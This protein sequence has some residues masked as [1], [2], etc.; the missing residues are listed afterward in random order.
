MP[1]CFRNKR[2][3]FLPTFVCRFSGFDRIYICGRFV[4]FSAEGIRPS[5][6]CTNDIGEI[7]FY[8]IWVGSDENNFSDK[9][10]YTKCGLRMD[11]LTIRLV[12]V[13]ISLK[14]CNKYI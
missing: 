3:E 13:K 4:Y 6:T 1:C 11:H 2:F 14:I 9:N 8:D 7:Q 10:I 12:F 5:Y